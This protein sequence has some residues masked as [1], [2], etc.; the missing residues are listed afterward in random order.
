[1]L[2]IPLLGLLAAL[3]FGCALAQADGRSHE[4]EA[5][6]LLQLVRADKLTVPVYAQVQQLFAQRF[7]QAKAS[8]NQQALLERYQA[9]A[10]AELDNAVGWGK[11]KAQ[12]VA[13]YVSQFDEQE[14]KDL[15]A[16]YQSSL[17][18]KVLQKMPELTAQSAHIT[19]ARLETAVPAVNKLLTEMS[20]QLD[21][22]HP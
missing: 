13:L 19:Q 15:I 10:N 7:A 21:A 3:M 1:M 22:K 2:R 17:G 14:I 18:R 16:F 4:A 20:N 6:R 12:M 11:L 8:Q 9:R 5:E